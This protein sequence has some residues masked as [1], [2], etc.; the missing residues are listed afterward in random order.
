MWVFYHNVT[1]AT[2]DYVA[3]PVALLCL[4]GACV[5]WAMFTRWASNED[6]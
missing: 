5:V 6:R 1:S 2:D 3:W 4:S